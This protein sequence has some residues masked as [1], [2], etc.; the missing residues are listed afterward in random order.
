LT[1]ARTAR[2]RPPSARIRSAAPSRR[3]ERSVSTTEAPSAARRRAV[4]SPMPWAAPV[5]T[6][7]TPSCLVFVMSL[8]TLVAVPLPLS[9]RSR[10]W[11]HEHD[12]GRRVVIA[13]GDQDVEARRVAGSGPR[14]RMA[15]FLVGQD[16]G[17]CGREGPG[18]T[19][20]VGFPGAP[21]GWSAPEPV[22]GHL[23]DRP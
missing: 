20:P 22:G 13:L 15:G 6:A 21:A 4:A 8:R 10:P 1:S 18:Q 9:V 3:G 7:V 17:A 16:T 19:P 12:G 2:A 14:R 5:T 23:G 11:R